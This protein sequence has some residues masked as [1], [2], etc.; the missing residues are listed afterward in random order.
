MDQTSGQ[1]DAHMIPTGLPGAGNV[2]VFDNDGASGF[3]P[4]RLPVQLESR[5]GSM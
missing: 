3:P 4:T 1:H 2:L 5:R